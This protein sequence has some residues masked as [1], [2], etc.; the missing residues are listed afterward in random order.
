MSSLGIAIKPRYGRLRSVITKTALLSE[1]AH[2]R[3]PSAATRLRGAASPSARKGGR[4]PEHQD[5][6]EW[7]RKGGAGVFDDAQPALHD[8]AIGHAAVGSG[9]DC[10]RCPGIERSNLLTDAV[11]Q[12]SEYWRRSDNGHVR[13]VRIADTGGR[14]LTWPGACDHCR[15]VACQACARGFRVRS[16]VAQA[17]VEQGEVQRV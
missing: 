6:E 2:S 10:A 14:L 8:I 11:H 4:Q 3:I 15:R 13:R 7:R 1:I 12:V 5:P 9:V 16:V 17:V